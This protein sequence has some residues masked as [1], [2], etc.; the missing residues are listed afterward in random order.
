LC[1]IATATFA[2]Y[3]IL[4]SVFSVAGFPVQEHTSAH[5]PWLGNKPVGEDGFYMLTVADYIAKTGHIVYNY[6]HPATGIQP[7]STFLFAGIAWLV[8]RL[9]GNEWTL[10]RAM[11]LEGSGLFLCFAWGISFFVA[12]LGPRDKRHIL[13]TLAFFLTLFDYD[14]FRLFVYGLETGLYLCLELICLSL[15][16]K[17]MHAGKATWPQTLM[18]GLAGGLAGL[19]RIDFG[20]LFAIVLLWLLIRRV[21]NPFQMLCCGLA[22]LVITSPWFLFVHSINGSWIPSSGRAESRLFTST[23]FGRFGSMANAVLVHVFPWI[24]SRLPAPAF[25]AL[26]LA[27]VVGGVILIRHTRSKASQFGR[28]EQYLKEIAPWIAGVVVLIA[29]YVIFF[30]VTFFYVRYT[31]LLFLLALPAAALL[32]SD[33]RAIVVKPWI[34]LPPLASVFVFYCIVTLHTGLMGNNWLLDAGYIHQYYPHAHVGSFQS[35]TIGYFDRNVDNLDGKL[36]LDALNAAAA[37][38]MDEYLDRAGI[39]VL[40]D[41][42][43]YITQNLPADYL[44]R[45]WEPCPQPMYPGGGSCFVRRSATSANTK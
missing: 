9:H 19:T 17:M 18:L 20:I 12:G 43:D 23:D 38:R 30:G 33:L 15:S 41:W 44:A 28:V 21:I 5:W 11:I 32:L 4:L 42:S 26:S 29:T 3:A 8:R 2:V 37:H 34:I 10:V 45:E 39:D 7:L 22:A 35:G 27:S 24:Y 36:N 14:I 25:A 6:G 1:A 40:V 31:S 16:W 13:F